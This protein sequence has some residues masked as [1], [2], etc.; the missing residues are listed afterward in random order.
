MAEVTPPSTQVTVR[1]PGDAN[2]ETAAIV[3][4]LQNLPRISVNGVTATMAECDA[5]SD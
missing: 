5:E 2:K 3:V 1:T 4:G